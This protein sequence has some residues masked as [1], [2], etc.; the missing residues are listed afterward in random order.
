MDGGLNVSSFAKR[1]TLAM[2][3]VAPVILA[4]ACSAGNPS[5]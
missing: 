3:L 5:A 1:D 2:C 4:I